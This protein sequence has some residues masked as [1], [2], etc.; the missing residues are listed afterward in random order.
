MVL[1]FRPLG[2]RAMRLILSMLLVLVFSSLSYG[3]S[4]DFNKYGRSPFDNHFKREPESRQPLA[5]LRAN[6]YDPNSLSNPYGAGSPYK[7]DGL[8]NPYSRYGSPYSN[9]S[10]RNPYA[11]NPPRLSNG[12]ELS[13]NPYRPNSTSNPYGRFGSPYSP[14]SVNNPYG[15]GN[16]YLNRPLYVFPSSR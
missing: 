10:W 5:D 14:D 1:L 12:G 9:D 8:M 2:D 16:P 3:Q 4:F 13:A 6:R 15:A 7:S 11:T